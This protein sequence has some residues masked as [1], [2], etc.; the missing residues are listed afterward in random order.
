MSDNEIKQYQGTEEQANSLD[1]KAIWHLFIGKWKWFVASVIVC[2]AL[3]MYYLLKTPKQYSRSA[4]VLIKDESKQQGI[5][6]DISSMFSNLGYS[7]GQT[8]VNNELYDIQ[9]PSVIWEAGHRL[10]LD[11]TYIVPGTFH[12]NELYGNTLPVSVRFL[13]L[14]DDQTASFKL[15]LSAN[16]KVK[17]SKFYYD[18]DPV[19][20]KD[21]VVEGYTKSISNAPV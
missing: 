15:E 9:A 14:T 19:G 17:M 6:S 7:M 2:V 8:N 16:G 21:K 11:V 18:G 13:G 3:G 12:D 4:I 5:G 10:G 1:M 20:E